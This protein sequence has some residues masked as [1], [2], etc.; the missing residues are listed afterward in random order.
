MLKGIVALLGCQLVGETLVRL[1]GARMPGPVIGMVLFFLVLQ[2]LR[3][4]E[5]SPLV[6]APS[7][8]LRHLQLLFVPAGVGIVVYLDRIRED[9]VPLAAGLWVSWAVGF[10]VTA[11]VVSGLLRLSRRRG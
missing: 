5:S 7:F 4:A 6:E 8:L 1:T 10:V 2:R 11:L 9:A 3:P